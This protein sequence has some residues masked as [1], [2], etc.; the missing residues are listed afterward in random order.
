MDTRRTQ[1]PR[2]G[3]YATFV[4]TLQASPCLP[5]IFPLSVQVYD[6]YMQNVTDVM[7]FAVGTT[8]RC[9]TTRCSP[10]HTSMIL[11]I[12]Y[13]AHQKQQTATNFNV[14]GTDRY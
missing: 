14:P 12:I 3:L 5:G 13:P 7:P 11:G 6:M 1:V 2:F 9:S 4:Y 10:W 8:H